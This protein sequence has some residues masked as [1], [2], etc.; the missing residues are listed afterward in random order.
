MWMRVRACVSIHRH[1]YDTVKANTE[2][3]C[4]VIRTRRAITIL[5]EFPYRHVQ[6]I[7]RMYKVYIGRYSVRI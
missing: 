6:I 3:R 5:G 4:D 2:G 1:V 7:L